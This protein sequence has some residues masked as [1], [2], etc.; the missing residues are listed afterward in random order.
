MNGIIWINYTDTYNPLCIYSTVSA[1][2]FMHGQ[3]TLPIL[4]LLIY[5]STAICNMKQVRVSVK[6]LFMLNIT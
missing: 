2:V 5:Y 1:H 6:H 4:P 3:N